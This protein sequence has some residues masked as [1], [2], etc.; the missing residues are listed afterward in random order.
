VK[1]LLDTHALIWLVEDD[2][3]MGKQA[4]EAIVEPGNDVFVSIVSFWEIAVKIR[5]G[6]LK[7][8]DLEKVMVA[9][10]SHGLE[11]LHLEQHHITE[12]IKLPFHL[13][14]RDPFDHQLIAQAIAEDLIFVSND[15]NTLRYP[16]KRIACSNVHGATPNR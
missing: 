7:K 6:K 9:V 12:L 11:L 5:I 1:L 14:H 3:R 13:D 8:V 4:R 10:T 16:V 15:R 2:A